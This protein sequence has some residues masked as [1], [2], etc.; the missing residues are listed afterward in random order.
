MLSAALLIEKGA[1]LV[2]YAVMQ[3]MLGRR[4]CSLVRDVYVTGKLVYSLYTSDTCLYQL[5]EP[6][7]RH[8]CYVFYH[9]LP[10]NHKQVCVVCNQEVHDPA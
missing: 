1:I 5:F 3:I 6:N 4:N 8:L 10:Q 2:L 9:T 7:F